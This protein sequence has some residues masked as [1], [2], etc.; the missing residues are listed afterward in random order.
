MNAPENMQVVVTK[1]DANALAAAASR[2]LAGTEGLI[3]DSPELYQLVS[4]DLQS[5]KGRM[6]E[7]ESLRVSLVDPF[8]KAVKNLN[9]VFRA[10]RELYEKA[11]QNIKLAM[12]TFDREQARKRAEEE[13]RARREAEEVAAKERARLAAIAEAERVRSEEAAAEL[14]RKADEA[15]AAGRAAEAAKLTSQ[16]SAK[17]D[18]GIAKVEALSEE[19]ANVV[20]APVA[21]T[22]AVAPKVAGISTKQVWKARIVDLPALV[23]FVAANP[24]FANLLEPNITAIN[25]LAKS[26]KDQMNVD[27]VEAY[28]EAQ[29]SSRAA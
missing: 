15:A 25:G 14:H 10:P 6:K 19:A 16:A 11:E 8:N 28:P 5:I 21:V 29:I 12:T 9:D 4:T 7:I 1:P 17:I 22:T 13:A 18:A 20:A 27:G 24:Q 2:V 3:V 26:L 23:K